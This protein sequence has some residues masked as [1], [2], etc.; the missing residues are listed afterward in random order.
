MPKVTFAGNPI[1]ATQIQG[2]IIKWQ[3]KG[4]QIYDPPNV[5]TKAISL[6]PDT[7]TTWP[8]GEKRKVYK[9]TGEE[10]M[11]Y[12]NGETVIWAGMFCFPEPVSEC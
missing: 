8:N 6:N 11:S 12:D 9:Y 5:I 4:G 1:D 2:A 7:L 3:L 10:D